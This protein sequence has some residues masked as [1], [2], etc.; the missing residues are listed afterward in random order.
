LGG[1]GQ[2]VPGVERHEDSP[3]SGG[4]LDQASIR[5]R[6]EISFLGDRPNVESRL[7]ERPCHGSTSLHRP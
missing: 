3:F 6:V 4:E 1:Q 2:E 5:H 7:A